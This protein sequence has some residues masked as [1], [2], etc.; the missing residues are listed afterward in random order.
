[1]FFASDGLWMFRLCVVPPSFFVLFSL[2]LSLGFVSS[3]SS[4]CV[5]NFFI[6][7]FGKL[8][9]YFSGVTKVNRI[10]TQSQIAPELELPTPRKFPYFILIRGCQWFDYR[11]DWVEELKAERKIQVFKVKDI[12]NLAD[13]LTK[14]YPTYKFKS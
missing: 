2:S 6:F 11:E 13:M 7:T 14:R 4:S 5:W 3:S 12:N 9:V 1:M 10:D 8:L